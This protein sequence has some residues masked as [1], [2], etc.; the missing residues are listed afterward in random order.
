MANGADISPEK[1]VKMRAWLARHESD[2]DGEGFYPDQDGFPSAGRVAWAL[3][4]GDPA[5]SWSNKLVGQMEREDAK[6]IHVRDKR[7]QIWNAYIEKMHGPAE[8]QFDK[9]MRDYLKGAKA[10]YVKRIRQSKSK[11][12][13]P[14]GV[15][16]VLDWNELQAAID[17]SIILLKYLKGEPDRF[18]N[19]R[20]ISGTPGA[21]QGTFDKAGLK[22]L[23]NLLKLAG[24][25]LPPNYVWGEDNFSDYEMLRVAKEISKTSGKQ[26]K[27]LVQKGLLEGE[28]LDEIADALADLPDD[29]DKTFGKARAMRI[30]RTE[31]T[32]AIAKATLRSY[33]IAEEDFDLE[34]KKAWVANRDQY[35]REEHLDL[36]QKYGTDEQAIHHADDFIIN[37][38][39][40]QGP[41][42]FGA[43]SMDINCRCTTVPVVSVKSD[44][45]PRKARTWCVKL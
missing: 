20:L 39:A 31:S 32:N 29:E 33:S 45:E 42:Q 26:I 23:R 27:E 21:W 18:E 44:S 41:G 6:K 17:E 28:S 8:K 35:T 37:G 30:A 3:W 13:F 25:P 2:K 14:N 4:G 12:S 7:A 9:A 10:R 1:A 19:G 40:G 43:A 24:K 36:E 5:V 38:F 16:K 34:V 15:D 11:K 22:T